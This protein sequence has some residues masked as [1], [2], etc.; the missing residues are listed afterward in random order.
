VSLAKTAASGGPSLLPD[1]LAFTTS[2]EED[3]ALFS[4]DV[5]GSIA[6]ARMLAAQGIIKPDEARQIVG[7]LR[8]LH[9]QWEKGELT[10]PDEEDVHMAVERALLAD[11]GDAAKVLHAARS[12][13][14][15]VALDLRLFLRE[16]ARNALH[17]IATLVR[18]LAER[19]QKSTDVFLPSYTHRQRAQPIS[20]AFLLSGYAE[21]FT[22]DLETFQFALSSL[23]RSPLGSGA[24]SG[25]S[26]PIDR[27]SVRAQLGFSELTGPAIDTVGDR[28]FA[29]D[30][31]YATSKLLVHV[32]RVA[33]DMVDF[34]SS[35]FGFVK[36]SSGIA[37]GSSM[38]PQKRNPDLFELLRGK[39]GKAIGSLMQLLTTMKGLPFGYNRDQQED[40][41]PILACATLS[42]AAPRMLMVG[43]QNIEFD[44]E[45]C[46]LALS[47]DVT[48]A[49]DIAEALVSRGVP[50]RESHGIVGR[51]VL[52]CKEK[53]YSL[54]TVPETEARA[55]DARLD[56]DVLATADLSR[57]IDRKAT[58]GGTATARVTEHAAHLVDVADKA[59]G[60]QAK[61]PALGAL[62]KKLSE[63]A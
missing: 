27:D 52:L 50:F 14:D 12:R 32:S 57:A 38:M 42:S 40:R 9:D 62:V 29:L 3:M 35:E 54:L 13:N 6:H 47:S 58:P 28:D 55:I 11:I 44:K 45:R 20:L 33:T 5:A 56:K 2:L 21:A 53:G 8:R 37:M 17:Q 49:T 18:Y 41:G 51:L 31:T 34:S 25:T 4:A 22:R 26:L 60:A 15:Q 23:G 7:G 10:L 24:S 30:Y 36:L 59:L 46:M 1:V 61:I 39:S 63:D 43:L 19:A 16:S 48:Q